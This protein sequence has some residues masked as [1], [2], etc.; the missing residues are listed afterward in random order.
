MSATVAQDL[1]NIIP[2]E[3]IP[4]VEFCKEEVTLEVGDGHA[5]ITG[6]Y[7]FRNNTNRDL[8]M[9]VV[10]PFYIDSLTAFP[11]HIE[12]AVNSADCEAVP[13]FDRVP[14]RDMVSLRI[15]VKA[16]DITSWRLT[17]QQE[18]GAKRAVYILTS[19][20][21]WKKPLEEATYYFI[22]PDSFSDIN[23][24]PIPDTTYIEGPDR[25]FKSVRYDF[26]PQRDMEITWK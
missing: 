8:Q 11:H 25:I 15:P 24:W 16:D 26:M 20:A 14:D 23:T 13:T 12:A 17:Y 6:I 9:P 7:Y 19:T 10:F 5:C 22:A 2:R 21:A 4:A 18:I 3:H 1:A